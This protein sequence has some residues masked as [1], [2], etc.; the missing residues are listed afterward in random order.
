MSGDTTTE[1]PVGVAAGGGETIVKREH[2]KRGAGSLDNT[3]VEGTPGCHSWE[4]NQSFG[5][6]MHSIS[7]LDMKM[8]L[9]VSE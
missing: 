6:E 1:D 8:A 2:R 3:S 9:M 5:P 7:C 4:C